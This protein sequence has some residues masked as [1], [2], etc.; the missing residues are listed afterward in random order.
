MKIR[1]INSLEEDFVEYITPIYSKCDSVYVYLIVDIHRKVWS[2]PNDDIY[3]NPEDV[4]DQ[5]II[6][7]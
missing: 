3:G 5:Y 2:I 4:T 1:H 7:D 6:K